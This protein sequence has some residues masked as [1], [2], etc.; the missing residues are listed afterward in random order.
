MSDVDIWQMIATALGTR[1]QGKLSPSQVVKKDWGLIVDRRNLIVHEADLDPSPP[2]N[3]RYSINQV[4]TDEA[5]EKVGQVARLIE[6][7][8]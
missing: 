4:M 6:A 7:L 3:R 8:L 5:L 2:R 1:K